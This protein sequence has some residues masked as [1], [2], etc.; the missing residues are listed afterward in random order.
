M[1]RALLDRTDLV[2]EY[3][4]SLP[5]I[6]KAAPA[7]KGRA[8]FPEHD[9]AATSERLA[10]GELLDAGATSQIS[11]V[12]G[13]ES[14]D[15]DALSDGEI[16]ANMIK[17]VGGKPMFYPERIHSEEEMCSGK[18]KRKTEKHYWV[19]WM[20]HTDKTWEPAA[21]VE[22]EAAFAKALRH[23][24]RGKLQ[25]QAQQQRT[26]AQQEL[27]QTQGQMQ[28]S[29]QHLASAGEQEVVGKDVPHV[30]G[31]VQ[32]QARE[33]AFGSQADT[34]VPIAVMMAGEAAEVTQAVEG[35]QTSEQA[36]AA[37]AA[38][39][40]ALDPHVLAPVR[41]APG[42]LALSHLVLPWEG[43]PP[44]PRRATSERHTHR[45]ELGSG[46]S[47]VGGCASS[48]PSVAAAS[49]S[50]IPN[51]GAAARSM[52]ER[53][54]VLASLSF[55]VRFAMLA[56]RVVEKEEPVDKLRRLAE[57]EQRLESAITSGPGGRWARLT[58]MARDSLDWELHLP[59]LPQGVRSTR[60]TRVHSRTHAFPHPTT[61]KH[62]NT[63]ARA[64]PHQQLRSC[65]QPHAATC[66][67]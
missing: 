36:V 8:A 37:A 30:E 12:I 44:R 59:R 3:T 17:V 40:A 23:Y 62:T 31:E 7:S 2:P 41:P 46:K 6:K 57:I 20:G 11:D 5:K 56:A 55:E 48:S 53:A 13:G 15:D 47:G 52:A 26:Q 22:R 58:T 24:Q 10:G 32:A 14:S 33:V 29:Q 60:L 4:Y 66:A 38:A 9:A 43:P 63:R 45:D 19:S 35:V 28:P 16:P 64:H 39:A 1:P 61:R 27:K 21:K 65:T 67:N 42:S 51:V 49:S 25:L 18:R 34:T 54:A 50:G